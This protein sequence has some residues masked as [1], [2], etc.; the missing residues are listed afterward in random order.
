MIP[1]AAMQIAAPSDNLQILW[2]TQF[3]LPLVIW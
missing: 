1:G 3:F 2:N